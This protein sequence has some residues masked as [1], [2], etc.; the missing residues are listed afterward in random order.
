M[1]ILRHRLPSHT[2]AR[3]LHYNPAFQVTLML[4]LGHIL[5]MLLWLLVISYFALFLGC[6][7]PTSN[8]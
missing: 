4:I 1:H 2:R 3:D 8:N 7:K 5:E 6:W